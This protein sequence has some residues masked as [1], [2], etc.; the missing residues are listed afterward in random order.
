M[1]D[2]I[3]KIV[4]YLPL[5]LAIVAPA[6]LVAFAGLK[7]M[8][9]FIKNEENRRMFV[10]HK[11]LQKQALPLRLQAYERLTLLLERIKPNQLLLRIAPK[12]ADKFIYERALVQAI[13]DEFEHN[14]TQQIYITKETW[15]VILTAKNT[16]IQLIRNA[17]RNEEVADT[18]KMREYILTQLLEKETPSDVALAYIKK[19]V[20]KVFR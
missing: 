4:E 9:R 15:N 2:F 13:T 11:E 14:I 20:R 10:L 18:Q 16:T 1:N 6:A 17:S 12:G 7:Y 19:E 3:N 8:D 5:A